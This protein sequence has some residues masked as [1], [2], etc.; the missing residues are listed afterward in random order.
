MGNKLSYILFFCSVKLISEIIKFL[1]SF[2]SRSKVKCAF[3]VV[4]RCN[5]VDKFVDL[6]GWGLGLDP[7]RVLFL[8][9]GVLSIE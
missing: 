7:L 6:K 9:Y 3:S 2:H 1:K 4:K 8:F 5:P